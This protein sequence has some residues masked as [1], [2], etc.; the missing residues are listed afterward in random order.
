MHVHRR[1]ALRVAREVQRVNLALDQWRRHD[2]H[3]L[4]LRYTGVETA[5]ARVIV[6]LKGLRHRR[7][8]DDLGLSLFTL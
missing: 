2:L 3:R 4:P 5:R 1:L 8:V 6:A 7:L